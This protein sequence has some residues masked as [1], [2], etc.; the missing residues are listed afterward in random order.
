MSELIEYIKL[1]IHVRHKRRGVKKM[2]S[3]GVKS[4]GLFEQAQ[5]ASFRSLAITQP[6]SASEVQSANFLFGSF[7]FVRAKEKRTSN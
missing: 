5:L 1:F 7:S 6:D 2:A 3:N 4:C